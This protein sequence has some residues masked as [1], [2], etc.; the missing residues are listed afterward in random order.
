M[1]GSPD[2]WRPSAS[3]E[4]LEF[5][6]AMLASLRAEFCARGFLEVETPVLSA[7]VCVD[8]H[9]EPFVVE[10]LGGHEM[11]LQTSPEFSM[12]R[13]V[14]DSS[15]PIFQVTRA[16]RRDE[17]GA[18]HNPEFTMIEWYEPDSSYLE[19]MDLVERLVWEV[20]QAAGES[21]AWSDQL[22]HGQRFGRLSYDEAFVR[23]IGV[24]VLGR[25]T[26]ELMGLASREL[27]SVPE[28]LDESD[29]DGWLNL[30]LCERVEPTLG[31]DRPEF[32]YDYPASQAALARIRRGEVDVAERMELYIGGLEICNGYQELT[33]ADEQAR[34][35]SE[36]SRRRAGTGGRSLPVSSR[37]ESALR[38]GLPECAGVALG[39]DRLVMCTLG[40]SRIEQVLAFPFGR[41]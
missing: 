10:G 2:D 8:E 24:E 15:R 41:A 17:S 35:M 5:R 7:D 38:A 9:L 39:F 4:V 27:E 36:Q 32:L 29:R 12:K 14:A 23:A 21:G 22:E 13:L 1:N 20:G 19:Q 16:F 30:L 34:R 26:S 28:G 40:L 18:R 37:L 33:D 31:R 3:W 11:F 6:A 25:S